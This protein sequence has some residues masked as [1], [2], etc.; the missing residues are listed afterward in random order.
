MLKKKNLCIA[1]LLISNSCTL[2]L[3]YTTRQ[4]TLSYQEN[5]KYDSLKDEYKDEA[6]SSMH[7]FQR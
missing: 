1:L 2:Y 4:E 5:R 3:L 6:V 7:D